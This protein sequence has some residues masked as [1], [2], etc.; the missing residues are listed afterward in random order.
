MTIAYFGRH[1]VVLTQPPDPR[2]ETLNRLHGREN[3]YKRVHPFSILGP[4]RRGTRQ[5]L[6][7]S[8]THMTLGGAEHIYCH[9]H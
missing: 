4:E 2:A 3:R 8:H 5:S 6:D 7:Q 9:V 1:R